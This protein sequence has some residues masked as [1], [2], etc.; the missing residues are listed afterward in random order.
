MHKKTTMNLS[1]TT[2]KELD[3]IAKHIGRALGFAPDRS[4]VVKWMAKRTFRDLERGNLTQEE[5]ASE[6][7]P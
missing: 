3:A 6:V 7:K 1:K 4:G 2:I 5:I